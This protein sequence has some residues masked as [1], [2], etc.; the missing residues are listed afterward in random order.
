MTIVSGIARG[1]DSVAH[2]ST[3][4]AGSKTVAVLGSGLADIYP[5]EN[6]IFAVYET[7]PIQF[8]LA[9]SGNQ[10]YVCVHAGGR[11]HPQ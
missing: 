7:R 4:A 1:I 10:R 2:E 11:S 3:I 9:E 8:P 5:P 6:G